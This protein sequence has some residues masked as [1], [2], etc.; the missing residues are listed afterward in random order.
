MADPSLPPGSPVTVRRAAASDA[1]ALSILAAATFPLACPPHVTAEAKADFIRTVLSVER[2]REYLADEARMLFVAEDETG[3]L[4][5]TMLLRGEPADPDAASAIVHRPTVEV[6]KC[7]AL[8]ARHGSGIAA[9]LMTA[10]IEEAGE[11]GARGVWLGVNQE[12]ARARRFYAKHGFEVV[13]TRRFLVG[14]RWEDDFVLERA[15]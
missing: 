13:G 8:P 10:S 7:Y 11:S 3:A 2:F 4:A 15:L 6:S 14:G 1:G 12:N 9:R 5:Y